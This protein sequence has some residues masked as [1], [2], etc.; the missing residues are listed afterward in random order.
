MLYPFAQV[1]EDFSKPQKTSENKPDERLLARQRKIAV[2]QAKKEHARVVAIEEAR[3]RKK[4]LNIQ[5]EQA[6]VFDYEKEMERAALNTERY[7][8]GYNKAKYIG[9]NQN[10]DNLDTQRNQYQQD[11]Q[12]ITE[13]FKQENKR[14]EE[15]VSKITTL[16]SQSVVEIVKKLLKSSESKEFPI[17]QNDLH[18]EAVRIASMA[19]G[20]VVIQCS[21]SDQ[22]RLKAMLG[23]DENIEIIPSSDMVGGKME[24][25]SK[26][27]HIDIDPQQWQKKAADM[28]LA[29]IDRLMSK[30][31]SRDT[32]Q[33]TTSEDEDG[34]Q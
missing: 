28:V 29:R 12:K 4:A 17:L 25:F 32:S 15:I 11:F 13:L 34:G 19:G 2:E 20:D 10:K 26:N 30:N 9:D 8:Q 1:L 27:S 33:I 21:L 16:F 24:I 23:T 5:G 18:K 3:L 31:A 22:E 14:R 6:K 7:Q